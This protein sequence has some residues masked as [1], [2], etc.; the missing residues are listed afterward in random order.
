MSKAV[1]FIEE[2]MREAMDVVTGDVKVGAGLSK[3]LRFTGDQAML[4]ASQKGLQKMMDRLNKTS[5]EYDM[6]ININN[7]KLMR[8]SNGKDTTVKSV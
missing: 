1:L 4:A 5:E 2:M 6:K 7:T 8:I 3:A